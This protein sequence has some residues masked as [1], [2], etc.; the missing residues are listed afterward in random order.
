MTNTRNLARKTSGTQGNSGQAPTMMNKLE[1]SF[2][3]ATKMFLS[4]SAPIFNF[5]LS[6][7]FSQDFRLVKD[8]IHL[9]DREIH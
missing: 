3:L 9:S 8:I 6:R 5:N 7:E 2:S 4:D 1:K